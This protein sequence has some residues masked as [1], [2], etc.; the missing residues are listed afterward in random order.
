MLAKWKLIVNKIW[1]S[2]EDDYTTGHSLHNPVNCN[3]GNK[4]IDWIR[5][6]MQSNIITYAQS[7]GQIGG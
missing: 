2:Y 1:K 4:M 6:D 3:G 7:R 5:S